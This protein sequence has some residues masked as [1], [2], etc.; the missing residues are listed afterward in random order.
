MTLRSPLHDDLNYENSFVALST[1]LSQFLNL[2]GIAS[3]PYAADLPH[4]KKLSLTKKRA[5]VTHLE[6]YMSLCVDHQMERQALRDSKK[7]TWRALQKFGFT[8]TSDFLDKISNA[9]VVEI[10]SEDHTQLFRNFEFFSFCSYTLEELFCLEWW[11]LF[12]R[13]P[14]VDVQILAMANQIFAGKAPE[15]FC[16]NL[17]TH[18]LEEAQSQ[19]RFKIKYEMQCYLPLYKNRR[20]EAVVSIVRAELV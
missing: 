20:V 17:E 11:N 5:V 14:K 1:Q 3:R 16:K 2:E 9:D 10:Y 4:F 6:S 12:R 15:G 8:P 7:F 18:I 13:D 19:D